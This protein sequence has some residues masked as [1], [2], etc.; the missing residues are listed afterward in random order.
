M[1][2]ILSLLEIEDIKLLNRIK[3]SL[4]FQ[5]GFLFFISI[6]VIITLWIF[7]YLDQK[8]THKEYDISRYFN[9]LSSIKSIL[10]DSKTIKREDISIFNMSIYKNPLPSDLKVTFEYE[11][12]FDSFRVIE[13]KNRIFLELFI[14]KFKIILED[15]HTHN[16]ILVVHS[17]FAILLITQLLL[18]LKL[19]TSLYPLAKL[20]SKL[21]NLKNGDL[22]PLNFDSKYREI[23]QI[24][25]SYNS[26]ISKIEYILEMREMFNKIFMHEIKMSIAKGLFYLKQKPSSFTH[27]K[28]ETILY[29]LNQE[30]D[31]FSTIESLIVYQNRLNKTP[32]S[33]VELIDEAI[34]KI[35]IEN[36]NKISIKIDKNF[37]LKG[38]RELWLLCFK[39]LI[40][41]A[42]KYSKDNQVKIES[43]MDTILFS[44]YGDELPVDLTKEIKRWKIDKNRR[45][46]S[47][48]GYGFGLFII[49]N[50]VTLQ[51]Y[52]LD[53]SFDRDKKIVNLQI[54]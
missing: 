28:L 4:I 34:E 52:K 27:Q 37:I 8:S 23:K 13:S 50:I 40:D 53:Y 9:S 25:L 43:N 42:L 21:K 39:N 24:I 51:G 41:N 19:K 1:K 3:Y 5:T 7:F 2:S 16:S 54:I 14:D 11:N 44:N 46:K 22:S 32:N 29:R 31:E 15:T 49:K 18:Y 26:S 36:K 12:H 20:E 6:I 17:V 10:I 47:S 33:L 38:D 30:L 48:T 45:H 35:G